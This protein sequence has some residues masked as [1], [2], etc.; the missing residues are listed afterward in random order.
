MPASAS[1][2]FTIAAYPR[3]LLRLCEQEWQIAPAELLKATALQ[4]EQLEKPELLVPLQDVFA[5]FLRA[6]QLT[7]APDLA[8]RYARCLP[9]GSHGLLGKATLTA[10]NLHAVIE[11]YY[12]YL[13]TVAPFVLMHQADRRDQ[14]CVVLELFNDLPM[15]E[16]FVMTLLLAAAFNICESILGS[17]AERLSVHLSSPP[18]PYADALLAHCRGGVHFNASFNGMSIPLDMLDRPIAT[19][20]AEAHAVVLGEI[21]ARMDVLLA[22]G[23]FTDGVRKALA[24]QIGSLPS[25]PEMAAQLHLPVRTV[26]AR[27]SQQGVSYQQLLDEERARRAKQALAAGELSVKAIAESLGF[28]DGSNFSRVFRRWTGL[29]PLGYRQQEQR[30]QEQLRQQQEQQQQ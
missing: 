27:L 19:A 26:R 14:R 30:Q 9:P 1:R 13:A 16:A 18:P 25:L 4:P 11:L 6:Q 3:K 20:D 24:Q 17:E 8:L 7:A 22:R 29:T 5:L 2:Q 10:A 15:D 28:Q 23:A 21:N 12:E